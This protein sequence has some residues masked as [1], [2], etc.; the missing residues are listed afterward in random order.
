[1]GN[2]LWLFFALPDWYFTTILM[3]FSAGPVTAI[4]ASGIIALAAG[5]AFAIAGR[6]PSILWG[7]VSVAA[8]HLLVSVAGLFRGQLEDSGLVFLG[9][10]FA[11]LVGLVYMVFVSHESRRAGLCIAWF[12]GTYALFAAFIASMSFADSWL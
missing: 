8:S 2:A 11:Q 4:P 3:P 9:F 5:L 12:C 10:L 1:M 6:E 7:L